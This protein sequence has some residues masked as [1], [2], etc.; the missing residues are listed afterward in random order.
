MM[1]ELLGRVYSTVM[2]EESLPFAGR[3]VTVT[4]LC[5]QATFELRAPRPFGVL[6]F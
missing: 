2:W 6:S 3:A 4:V 1:R 5:P